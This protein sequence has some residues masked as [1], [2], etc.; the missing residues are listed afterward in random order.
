MITPYL[1]PV[2]TTIAH[3]GV[4]TP[5]LPRCKQPKERGCT[6]MYATA[7]EQPKPYR[8][9]GR[10]V[11]AIYSAIPTPKP[12]MP[13]SPRPR[14][15]YVPKPNPAPRCPNPPRT[16]CNRI[17]TDEKIVTIAWVPAIYNAIT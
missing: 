12:T 2:V 1:P 13:R 4:S 9:S 11:P 14:G 5:T 3:E 8:G 15:V 10:W 17:A 7:I 16:G 6:T